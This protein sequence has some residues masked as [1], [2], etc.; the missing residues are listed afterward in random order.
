MTPEQMRDAWN[1]QADQFNQWGE[2]DWKEMLEWAIKCLSNQ[3]AAPAAPI[4]ASQL[5]QEEN[6]RL[7][8][9]APVQEPVQSAA[10]E[11]DPFF[12]GVCVALQSLT[13][14]GDGVI[15]REIVEAAG[16]DEIFRYA[17]HI[18]PE[19]WELAGFSAFAKSEMGRDKPKKL[20]TP[21]AAQ[22]AQEEIQRLR[23]L[24][25]AQQITIDKLEAQPE[26]AAIKTLEFLGY[27]YHGGEQWKP[28]LGKKP[29]W[30]EQ[31]PAAWVGLTDEEKSL[32][33]SWLD[34]KTDDEVFTAIEAKLREKNI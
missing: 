8:A 18:E 32:F 13:A 25:R 16:A 4:V 31:Q 5:V 3:I 22:P 19:E 17:A 23:A 1:A 6:Q 7:K 28:P 27:T 2:L 33:S 15:W 30:L 9:T 21:P 20:A 29:K 24:V 11:G 26:K 10:H 34:H 14:H 12:Q